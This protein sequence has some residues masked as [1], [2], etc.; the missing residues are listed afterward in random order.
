MLLLI[1]IGL[2]AGVITGV[3]P[4]VLPVL[5]VLFFAGGSTQVEPGRKRA[6]LRRSALVIAGVVVSFSVLTLLG[7]TILRAVGLPLDFLRWA[8]LVVLVLVGLGLIFPRLEDRLQRPFR[9]LPKAF[10]RNDS[11]R[12]SGFV[13]GLAVGTLYVPCAGPVLAAISIAG[14]S[15]QI[16][17]GIAALTIAFSVGVAIPLFAFAMAGAGISQRLAA[18]RRR[19]RNFRVA[20]GT[21]MVLLAVALTFDLTDGLQRIVPAYTQALQDEVEN[22][23]AAQQALAGLTARTPTLAATPAPAPAT[24]TAS[25]QPPASGT[26]PTQAPASGA[27]PSRAARASGPVVTCVSHATTLAN[28]GRAPQFTGISTWLNTPQDRPVTLAS[29]SGHVVLV[30]FWT[31]SCINCQRALPYVKAWY[32]RYHA[33]GLDIV[34]IHTPEFSYEHELG[35][36][37]DAVGSDGVLYPVGLDNSSATWRAYDNSY[38]PA[39]YLVDAQGVLRHVVYGE[40]GYAD[41]EALIRALLR[42][43]NPAVVLPPPTDPAVPVG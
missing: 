35:N 37:R 9:N 42:S 17:G 39:E 34:G 1:A 40:G 32:A 26:A 2:L 16:S 38:W 6:G 36:V 33:S 3:S 14:S 43:Q 20:G 13:L 24:R 11:R 41:S 19:S 23:P 21:V 27:A 31:F 22:N 10:S 7:T 28:C 29:M 8:G 4:C 25:T 18:F 12:G 30:N 5:P 15:G